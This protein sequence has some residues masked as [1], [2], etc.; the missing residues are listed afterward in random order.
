MKPMKIDDY[1]IND[2]HVN[3]HKNGLGKFALEYALC[4]R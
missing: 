2:Y 3:F 4:C 1:V